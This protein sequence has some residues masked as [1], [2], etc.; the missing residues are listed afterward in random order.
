MRVKRS[1]LDPASLAR[2]QRLERAQ[3]AALE[4]GDDET[5]DA[6]SAE[7]AEIFNPEPEQE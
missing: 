6:I 1:H 3:L 7:I 4:V 2:L 5:A